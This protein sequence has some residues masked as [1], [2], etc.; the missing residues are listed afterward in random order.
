VLPNPTNQRG[1]H[2]RG[3]IAVSDLIEKKNV[4]EIEI[5]II[6]IIII[7]LIIIIIIIIITNINN[8]NTGREC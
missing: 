8:N 1:S 6:I 3:H 5:I 4:N 2:P 7:I